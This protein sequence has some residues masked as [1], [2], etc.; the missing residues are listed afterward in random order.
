MV[1]TNMRKYVLN[2]DKLYCGSTANAL[3]LNQV[4]R[5]FPILID[6][7]PSD[8]SKVQAWIE[9]WKAIY[10]DFEPIGDLNEYIVEFNLGLQQ[11]FK[12]MGHSELY[13]MDDT[14]N[15]RNIDLIPYVWVNHVIGERMVV[16]FKS[17]F[18]KWIQ[19][20]RISSEYD[21]P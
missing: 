9:R 19:L 4:D 10:K 1:N 8:E 20:K 14:H 5:E 15:T 13:M 16:S 21:T 11:K 3:V 12:D 6:N 17:D 18:P 2:I 7:P